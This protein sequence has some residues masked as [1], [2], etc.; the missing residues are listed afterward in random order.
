MRSFW[1]FGWLLKFK[2]SI[3]VIQGD[4]IIA[5]GCVCELKTI[6]LLSPTHPFFSE[7]FNQ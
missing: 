5:V 2:E 6:T 4:D 3:S 7:Y 1:S